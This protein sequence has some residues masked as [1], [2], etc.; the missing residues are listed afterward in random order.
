MVLY[1]VVSFGV[2][3][4]VIIVIYRF[5]YRHEFDESPIWRVVALAAGLM[6]LV[7]GGSGY[8]DD[9]LKKLLGCYQ[10]DNGYYACNG[11]I[12]FF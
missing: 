8:Y 10:D 12:D 7:Y 4:A 11:P 3:F 5:H 2:W 6:W 1:S 9:D